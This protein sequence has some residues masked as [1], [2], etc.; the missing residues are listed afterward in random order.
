MNGRGFLYVNAT[1][2]LETSPAANAAHRDRVGS[3]NAFFTWVFIINT[4]IGNMVQRYT[5]LMT[6]WELVIQ[7]DARTEF[8]RAAEFFVVVITLMPSTYGEVRYDIELVWKQSH[9]PVDPAVTIRRAIGIAEATND[10][11]EAVTNIGKAVFRAILIGAVA[12]QGVIFTGVKRKIIAIR[13]R[14]ACR[15][16]SDKHGGRNR[17]FERK[18]RWNPFVITVA[19]IAD[20]QAYV[21]SNSG[22]KNEIYQLLFLR[23]GR[24]SIR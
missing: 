23:C 16:S 21:N 2:G 14:G 15:K 8:Q 1:N 4:S 5:D 19:F 11:M 18:H 9:S 17:R 7:F 6:I 20:S 22:S 3:N 13:L 12:A 24:D 10:R